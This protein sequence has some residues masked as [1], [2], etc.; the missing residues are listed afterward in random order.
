MSE[1]NGYSKPADVF[2][3][4]SMRRYQDVT[5]E[6]HRFCLRNWTAREM[7]RFNADNRKKELRDMANERMIAFTCVDPETKEP[8]FDA[9]HVDQLR[10]LDAGFIVALTQAC[11][12][13]ISVEIETDE[14]PEK[15]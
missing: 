8:I 13:H 11:T 3:R 1:T 15:N 14:E 7:E 4:C 5:I 10:D 2:K 6:G 9:E 12:D